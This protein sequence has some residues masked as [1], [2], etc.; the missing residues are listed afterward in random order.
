M[1]KIIIPIA[2]RWL[3]TALPILPLLF[4]LAQGLLDQLDA[5]PGKTL[6]HSLGVWALRLLLITLCITPLQRYTP[7]Q[8]LPLRR[9]LGLYTLAYALLHLLAYAFFYLGLDV[10]LLAKELVKRPYIVVGAVALVLLILLGL[11]STRGWQRRLGRRWKW[12][13][14][15]VYLIAVL[16]IVHFAWQVKAGWG[17]APWYGLIFVVLML[18]RRLPRQ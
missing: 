16:A 14:L 12:L 3:L 15:S 13:H 9:T 5:D 10:S 2:L 8:W 18:L 1:K 7:V 11:T 6:V 4:L 17:D